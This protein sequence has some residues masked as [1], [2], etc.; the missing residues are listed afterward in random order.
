MPTC[1]E[2]YLDDFMAICAIPVADYSLG[3]LT[4][5]LDP[6]ISASEFAP[7]LTN[8]VVI[9][10]RAA[11]PTGMLIPI[12]RFTGKVNDEESDAAAGRSHIV[13]VTCKAD[14]RD[15]NVWPYMLVLERTPCHLILTF[16]NGSKGFVTATRDS[17]ISTK[18]RD[19]SQT[20][21]T[22]KIHNLM[23]IQLLV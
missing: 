13:T 5:Q 4:W 3:T 22:F 7:P 20:T 15:G 9:G 11:T 2:F 1:K 18:E 19:G 14:D 8:A 17:Y 16:R 21:I 23:G 10:Q 6:V 12:L